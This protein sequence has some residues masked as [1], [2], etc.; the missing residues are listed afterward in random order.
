M[1]R[2]RVV[3]DVSCSRRCARDKCLTGRGVFRIRFLLLLL[4]SVARVMSALRMFCTLQNATVFVSYLPEG[5]HI[6]L[7][8][9]RAA[10]RF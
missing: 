6:I 4:R 3:R 8:I 10:I 9:V 1:F 2:D 7:Y 5:Q